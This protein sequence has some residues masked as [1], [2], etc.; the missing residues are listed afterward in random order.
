MKKSTKTSV[1]VMPE[2][3]KPI[4]IFC[5]YCHKDEAMRAELET[6]LSSL[7]LQKTIASWHDRNISARAD[8]EQEID[9]DLNTAQIILLLISADFLASD[10]CN[11]QDITRALER[12]QDGEAHVIPIIV[13]PVLWEGAP[14]SKL[15]VLPKDGM[16]IQSKHWFN[17]DEA[18]LNVV[19][20]LH[21]VIADITST[22]IVQQ[23]VSVPESR[24]WNVPYHRN[25]FFTGREDLLK[26]V[27]D[28]L[29]SAKVVAL[30]QAEAIS[31][32]GGI[33][34]TQ[35]ALEYAYR[36]WQ[37][38]RYVFWIRAATPEALLAD[39]MAIATQL[40]L[41]PQE[42][43][44]PQVTM[45]TVKAWLAKQE[46]WL[47]VI[48]NF[49][50]DNADNPGPLD[51]Y[52]PANN[53]I[54]GHILLITR[55]QAAG[56]SLA[57]TITVEQMEKQEAT[58]LLLRRAKILSPD[59][60]LDQA[61]F[62]VRAEA[63]A[64]VALLG[65]FPFALD[66]AGT[67]IHETGCSLSG[68]LALYEDSQQELPEQRG[69]SASGYPEAVAITWSICFQA[70]EQANPDATEFLRLCAFLNPDS[71]PEEM[72]TKGSVELGPALEAV[73]SDASALDDA[74][75]ELRQ[76]S[77]VES[78]AETGLVSLHRLVQAMLKDDMD[79]DTQQVWAERAIR[80]V[81]HAFRSINTGT[82]QE[83]Q[84]YFRQI[85]NCVVLIDHY[86]L[87]FLE[88]ANL[89]L[90]AANMLRI[91][92]YYEQA[93]QLLP[94]VL[95]IYEE[96]LGAEHPNTTMIRNDLAVLYHDQDKHEQAELLL[97]RP[98]TLKER[99]L[100]ARQLSLTTLND[101]SALPDDQEEY[102]QAKLFYQQSLHGP[103]QEAEIEPSET[104]TRLNNLALLYFVEGKYEQAEPL[105]RRALDIYEKVQGAE[106]P[107][108]AATLDNLALLY[109]SQGKYEQAELLYQRTL[110]IKE[111]VWEA[112]HPE[113]AIT[114][115]NLALLYYDQGKYEQAEP[116]YQRALRITEEELGTGHASTATI[117]DNL[118][119]L[120]RS[121]GKYEQAG[122]LYQR[123]L[124]IRKNVW[125][126]EHPETATTL[127][128]L[129]LLCCDQGKYEQ[130]EPLYLQAMDIYENA[131]G[132][133]HP[134]VATTLDN[135]AQL[136]S[137]QG[138]YEQAEPLYQL[139]LAIAEKGL[140]T[141]H[142]SIATIVDNL[143]NLYRSQGKYEQ[144]EPLY[145]RALT[146]RENVLGTEHPETAITLN[147]LA[148]LCCDQGKYEQAQPLYQRALAIYE[149]VWDSEHPEIATTLDNL[150]GLYS[151]QGEYEQAEP[152][153]QRAL[154]IRENTL[155]TEHPETAITLNNL[156][157][158]YYIQSKYEEADPLYQRALLI[159]ENVLGAEHLE[160]AITLNNL[161]EVYYTQSKYEQAEPLYQRALVIREKVLG[162]EH[163]ETAATLDNLAQ[164]YQVQSKYE[165]AEPLY[166]R[167]F[168]I[169][170][171]VLGTEHPETAT[172]VDNLAHLYSTQGKYEQAEPLYLRALNIKEQVWGAE[173]PEVATTLDN[174]AQLYSAQGK[175]KQAEPLYQRA[176][177]IAEKGLG[178]EHTSTATIVDNL[179]Q[180]YRS[181]GK[182][183]RA[184]PLYVRA[185]NIREDVWGP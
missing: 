8:W 47:L 43:D 3:G 51:H 178:P 160:T 158:L 90:L 38:Y 109:R 124:T 98:A 164:L 73:T 177:S 122:P 94:R 58:L 29:T 116:L 166:L 111:K 92:A 25:A 13:R 165:Q 14:F 6:H 163:P 120:Y 71:I 81:E 66:Q 106:H 118:A 64:I 142:T 138:K 145:L 40:N 52:F 161:A 17:R 150:A 21:A 18:W 35:I 123:A 176:L 169:Y 102:E 101:W 103:E 63:E 113:I 181:Q 70:V 174:L 88:A 53:T 74:I 144:A 22:E 60:T 121:Q 27:H 96:V 117:V 37:E 137:A 42:T 65:N 72:I 16:P 135:L 131:W 139:A 146:I 127:N 114:L 143:A 48:D 149:N 41:P 136:Y 79:M 57:H 77:L 26:Q 179:A 75:K 15:Q 2:R 148:L 99:V 168:A 84:P 155:G 154:L 9:Q 89:L 45:M 69:H 49:G 39:F 151:A 157:G 125:G 162:A 23:P 55:A 24:V 59:A 56:D 97:Q 129:A 30:T 105:Y 85:Q 119:N 86:D 153:Y 184:G 159:R 87:I 100:Q 104:A 36:Y 185:L 152:L 171:N 182:Y 76:F 91:Y 95:S 5:L 68:Y 108:F 130:A 12:H 175:Y 147:N 93:T 80:T 173:H 141:E 132:T 128:N 183:D 46:N 44:D 50:N 62:K 33:G 167:A 140:G 112:D 19:E 1:P 83:C 54:T 170:E 28:T 20:G 172:I 180:L 134:E 133:E 34:K 115:N 11:S 82:W 4:K 61:T 7:H 78:N 126:T 10:Y 107:Q 110:A 31:D 32:F 67:Y 156:A